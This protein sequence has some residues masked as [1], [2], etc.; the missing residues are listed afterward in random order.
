MSGLKGSGSLFL[1]CFFLLVFKVCFFIPLDVI[2]L[3]F[4]LTGVYPKYSAANYEIL[5]DTRHVMEMYGIDVSG[6]TIKVISS[7]K[8]Y[9]RATVEIWMYGSDNSC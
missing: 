9:T 4:I 6:F 1:V 2:S 8:L 3:A 5:I 7:E